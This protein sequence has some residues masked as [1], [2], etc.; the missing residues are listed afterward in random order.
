MTTTNLPRRCFYFTP[1]EIP[2]ESKKYIIKVLTVQLQSEYADAPDRSGAVCP[3]VEDKTWLDL[4]LAQEKQHGLGVSLILRGL[5]VDAMPYIKEAE[6]SVLEGS[7]KLDYFRIRMDDWVERTLT[8][9]LAERTGAIQTVAGLG[10]WYVPLAIWHAKNYMDEALGHT[11]QGVRYAKDLIAQGRKEECQNAVN[12]FYPSCLD[13]FGGVNTPNEK[14]YLEL[15]IKTLSNNQTRYLWM[16]SLEKDL[17]VLGLE[18]PKERWR[19]DRQE[20]PFEDSEKWFLYL[21]PDESSERVREPLARLL[22][23]W[24]QSKYGRQSDHLVFPA[25]SPEEKL[26]VAL[27][28]KQEKAW[29]LEIAKMLRGLGIDPN[30]LADEA[31]RSPQSGRYKLEFLRRPLPKTWE[32]ISVKQLLAARAAAVGSLATFGSCLIPLAVWSGLHY[33]GESNFAEAWKER[34]KPIL[35]A[36]A[37]EFCQ[38]ALDEWYPYAVDLFGGDGTKNEEEYCNLGIK[39]ATNAHVREIFIEL[40]ERDM[41]ELGLKMPEARRGK[42]ATYGPFVRPER[43]G[44]EE[45]T[46]ATVPA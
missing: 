29:G 13:I 23:V 17:T 9:V 26:A 19:G 12:K 44:R 45:S 18:M 30:S 24:V 34:L 10:G 20:Y 35:R 16:R 4:Q 37:H 27:Q 32:E 33:E 15:G 43:A 21:S 40:V 31:E 11:V 8:R 1:Q 28:L 5:G 22:S 38:R 2:E 39:T 6:A 14:K 36:G 46:A 25:P 41:A 42:K 3:T 7:R